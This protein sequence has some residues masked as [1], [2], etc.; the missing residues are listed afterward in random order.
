MLSARGLDVI[1]LD[2]SGHQNATMVK[3]VRGDIKYTRATDDHRALWYLS[4]KKGKHA[5]GDVVRADIALGHS[6]TIVTHAV[7]FDVSP[8]GRRLALY[9]SGDLAGDH[10]MPVTA[11]APGRVVVM[12]LV[13]KTSSAASVSGVTSLRFS[14]DGSYIAAVDCGPRPCE[15]FARIEVPAELGSP[16]VVEPVSWSASPDQSIRSAKIEFGPGGLFVLK[17][18]TPTPRRTTTTARIDR[19][20][21]DDTHSIATILW[22]SGWDITQIVPTSTATYVVASPT[23]VK[24]PKWG[25]YQVVEGKL[26]FV[27]SLSDPGTL[28]PVTPLVGARAGG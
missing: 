6:S 9:G 16:L 5:C 24:P 2:A 19:L 13:T 8:D 28:T 23:R 18:V 27:R 4:L 7:A 15:S 22:S 10:C 12:D 14:P 3:A 21:A 1:S 26:T 20:D 11:A 25:L 17:Q